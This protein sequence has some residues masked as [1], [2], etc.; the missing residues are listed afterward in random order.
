[1]NQFTGFVGFRVLRRTA[2][3]DSLQVFHSF[4][5]GEHIVTQTHLQDQTQIYKTVQQEEAGIVQDIW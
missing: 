1:M 3:W 2:S 5:R 4:V